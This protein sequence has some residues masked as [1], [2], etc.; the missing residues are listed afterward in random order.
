MSVLGFAQQNPTPLHAASTNA[1]QIT[2][3][4]VIYEGTKQIEV[5]RHSIQEAYDDHNLHI[6]NILKKALSRIHHQF[7]VDKLLLL[8]SPALI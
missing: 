3:N 5:D 2:A 6:E 4:P 8:D 1:M 7:F